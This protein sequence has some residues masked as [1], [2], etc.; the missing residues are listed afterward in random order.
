MSL[1]L[2]DDRVKSEK[3]K[4]DGAKY[5]CCN[6]KKKYFGKEDV[7]KCFDSH[8]DVGNQGQKPA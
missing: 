1:H 2:K 8:A 4:R 3:F 5:I 6:C 7:E